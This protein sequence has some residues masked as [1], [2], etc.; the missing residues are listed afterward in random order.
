MRRSTRPRPTPTSPAKSPEIP[1]SGWSRSRIPRAGRSSGAR[2]SRSS[3]LRFR[4]GLRHGLELGSPGAGPRGIDAE[5]DLTVARAA[6]HRE[7]RATVAG[8]EK[9]HSDDV[10]KAEKKGMLDDDDLQAIL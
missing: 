5:V 2:C 10:R 8:R 7:G 6:Q 1:T 4:A 9:F 3:T